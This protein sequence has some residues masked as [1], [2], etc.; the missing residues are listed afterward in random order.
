[1]RPEGKHIDEMQL[2]ALVFQQKSM[3][4]VGRYFGV[5]NFVISK[6][7]RRYWGVSGIRRCREYLAARGFTPALLAEEKYKDD[8]RRRV[9]EDIPYSLEIAF[10]NPIA[11]YNYETGEKF[12]RLAE[13]HER[14]KLR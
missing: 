13:Y 12:N 7:M 4:A 14:G 5:T 8:P 6:W 11:K 10:A 9:F 3:D 1:M 2:A